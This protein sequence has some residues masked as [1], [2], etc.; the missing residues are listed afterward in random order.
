[1]EV[2]YINATSLALEHINRVPKVC[3]LPRLSGE[4][5]QGIL[6]AVGK[7]DGILDS[8]FGIG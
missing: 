4:F 2:K 5:A 7:S 8:G 1:M 3:S 6:G